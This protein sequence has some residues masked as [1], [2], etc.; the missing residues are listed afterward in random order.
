[1]I[2][3]FAIREFYAFVWFR[4]GKK[5]QFTTEEHLLSYRFSQ[6]CYVLDGNIFFDLFVMS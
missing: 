2:T 5:A 6:F 4:W 3:K 1:M